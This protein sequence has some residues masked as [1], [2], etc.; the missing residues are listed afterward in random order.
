[1]SSNESW[2]F[3]YPIMISTS[4]LF[5]LLLNITSSIGVI[6]I[7]K[8]LVFVKAGFKFSTVLTIIH[9]VMTFAGCLFFAYGLKL[10]TPKH[11]T[12]RQ[13][14]PISSAF[15]GYVVFNN[16]SLL[17]N[18]V[19]VYQ[20]LKILCTPIIVGIERV[21]YGKRERMSTLLSLIP[22]CFGV[23]ITFYSDSNVN[24][25]GT[26]WAGL[27]IVANSLYTIWGKTKQQE[28]NAQPMQLLIYQAP[29]S[30]VMLLFT[31]IPID[32]YENLAAYT[33]SFTTVWTVLLSCV[34]AFG[35]NFSF[36][37]FVGKTSPL[38]MNVVGY[39]K[40]SLV[41]LLDFIFVSANTTPQKAI[42][43]LLTLMGLAGYSY[44]KMEPPAPRSPTVELTSPRVSLDSRL[45]RP[46]P[47]IV[48]V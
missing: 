18:S 39:L 16:L 9:F 31:A 20:V 10:F 33:V 6:I 36:F 21:Y 12:I 30:A 34:F 23:A 17:T 24:L 5:S 25:V 43:I 26:M 45:G 40:T 4:L 35:V 3:F 41:F 38:T 7:N 11:L 22:V 44:S 37:L 1:M 8:Q 46:E 2:V 29:I 48:A 15:C 47:R 28:L 13:V 42:G 19:S 14:L 27:A 32:G